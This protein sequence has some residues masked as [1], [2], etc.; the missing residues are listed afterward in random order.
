MLG[1][2]MS[3]ADARDRLAVLTRVAGATATIR[4]IFR[5]V[6]LERSSDLRPNLNDGDG[7]VLRLVGNTVHEPTAVAKANLMT[8]PPSDA[9]IIVR[10]LDD[11]AAFGEIFDRHAHRIAG[12]LYRRDGPEA[13]DDLL[14]E[15]FAV[16]F[17]QRST[18]DPNHEAAIGWLY[19]IATNLLRRRW[20]STARERSAFSRVGAS[21]ASPTTPDEDDTDVLIAR[22]EALGARPDLLAMLRQLD[23]GQ[24]DLLVMWAWEQLTYAE[25]ADALAIPIGTVRSRIHRLKALCTEL[26]TV[27]RATT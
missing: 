16:A 17:Q 25:I 26:L 9:A 8:T 6:P 1:P 20:R 27:E 10:S 19:G 15:V 13:R 24:V 2:A 4:G 18:Y 11:P 3:C 5:T 23:G 21:I 12:Y 7:T 22:V 14:T